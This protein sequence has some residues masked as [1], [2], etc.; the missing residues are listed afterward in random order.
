MDSSY[1]IIMWL[2]IG[3]L[4]GWIASKIMGTDARQGAI[5]NVVVGV[6]GAALGGFLTRAFFGGA[7]AA[8]RGFFAS[9]LVATLGAVVLLAI[10]RAVMS[11]RTR[12]A[13]TKV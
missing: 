9:L 13:R 7:G 3:T 8:G 2:V 1:G 6:V 11:A 10:Y 4:A 5:G 12:T